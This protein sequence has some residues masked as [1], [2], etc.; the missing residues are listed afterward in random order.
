MSA[1]ASRTLMVMA[2]GTAGHIFGSGR[3][4]AYCSTRLTSEK[5]W[6]AYAENVPVRHQGSV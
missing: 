3:A 6:L 1:N 5:R 4:T 2:G